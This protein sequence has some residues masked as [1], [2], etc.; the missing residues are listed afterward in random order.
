METQFEIVDKK[1]GEVMPVLALAYDLKN[2]ARV[3]TS[4]GTIEFEQDV[5]SGAISHKKYIFRTKGSEG[6]GNSFA[7]VEA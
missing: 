4:A 3:T 7:D 2:V 5:D 1:T 6:A